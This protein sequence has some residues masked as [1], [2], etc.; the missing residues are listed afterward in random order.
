MPEVSKVASGVSKGG[1]E[2]PNCSDLNY[3]CLILYPSHLVSERLGTQPE[4]HW[5]D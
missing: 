3:F 2:L 5:Q 1:K 4:L